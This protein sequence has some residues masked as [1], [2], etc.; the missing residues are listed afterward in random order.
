MS[1]TVQVNDG[2]LIINKNRRFYS[3]RGGSFLVDDKSYIY[4]F[5]TY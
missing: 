5:I 3:G 2:R 4:F 1:I